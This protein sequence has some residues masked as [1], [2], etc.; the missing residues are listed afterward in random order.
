MDPTLR[1]LLDRTQISETIIRYFNGLDARDWD[2]VRATL[3]GTIDL[4]FSE[5]FGDPRTV[6]DSDDF[7]AFAR[8]VLSGFRHT[9]H[10]SPNHVI[11]IEGE[12]AS[13]TASMYAWHSVPAE[14]KGGD[15]YTLRGSYDVGLVRAEDGWRID[16]L[17]MA[18]WDEAGNK[19]TY[20][21]ARRRYEQ[22]EGVTAAGS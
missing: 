6:H 8:N 1:Y 12:R 15:T 10:I 2:A 19:E 5:L 3:A 16:R 11:T 4:D 7:V 9:Q 17:H 20:A 22:S 14:G 13:A 18:V 21:I